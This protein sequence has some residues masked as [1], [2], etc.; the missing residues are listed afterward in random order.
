MWMAYFTEAERIE[1]YKPEFL[2]TLGERSAA[3][4]IRD[5]Y[6]ASDAP[7][8]VDRLLDVD[9][10]TILP[11]DLLV[12]MDIATMAHSLEV[13]SPRLDQEFRDL[14]AAIPSKAKLDGRTSKRI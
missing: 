3:S 5:P 14:A 7:D 10:E 2:E 13:R 11:G 1:L 6:L 12:K 4:V 8:L 9:V